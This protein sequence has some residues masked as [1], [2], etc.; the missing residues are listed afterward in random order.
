MIYGN[1]DN[2]SKWLAPE[3]L[4]GVNEFIIARET[5]PISATM[6]RGMLTIGDERSWQKTTPQFIHG[7]YTRL[8]D[9][10]LSVPVY[11]DIYNRIRRT[12]MTLDEFMKVYEELEEQ[13]KQ[14]SLQKL[15][16]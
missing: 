10:L 15:Q 11:R 3:D 8:R 16:K 6:V 2:R 12:E 13:N 1:D 4:V 7:I 9:E 5:L 14:K